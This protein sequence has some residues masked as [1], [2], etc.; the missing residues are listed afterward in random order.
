MLHFDVAG[1]ALVLAIFLFA[2]TVKGVAGFGLPTISLGLLA[3]TRPMQ[4]AI[5]LALLPTMATNVWQALGGGALRP[6]VSRL[7]PFF[8]ASV[9]GTVAAA[10]ALSRA[11]A[12]VLTGLLGALMALSAAMALLGPRWP[13][14]EPRRERWL[15]PVVGATSGAVTGLTGSYM[16][17]AAP[18]LSTLRLSP[19]GFVQAFA[20]GA[21]AATGALS[22][23]MAAQGLLP[24]RLGLA[25]AMGLVP[26]FLGMAVGR[27][28]RR[29]FSE[30]RFR[31][32]IQCFLLSLGLYLM[33]RNLAL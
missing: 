9:F 3:L 4:E 22:L 27:R 10:G 19:D 17:P 2:G 6:T 20:L 13:E 14:P 8:L 5:A 7:W 31:H 12:A 25:S 30:Q 16:M 11:D 18:Y 1:V 33:V 32:V 24:P 21:L 15:S 23:A 29:G 28:L 26:A